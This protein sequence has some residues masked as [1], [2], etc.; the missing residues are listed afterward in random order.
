MVTWTVS[1]WR[2]EDLY[3]REGDCLST[4]DKPTEGIFNGSIL[5]EM[6]TGNIYKFNQAAKTWLLTWG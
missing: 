2:I 4:D 1:S 5:T 6:D 3:Y